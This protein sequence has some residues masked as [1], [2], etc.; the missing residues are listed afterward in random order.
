MR[1]PSHAGESLLT[2]RAAKGSF[3]RITFSPDNR[4]IAYGI[5]PIVTMRNSKEEGGEAYVR[6][7]NMPDLGE[8][9]PHRLDDKG[10]SA[11]ALSPNGQIAVSGKMSA[12]SGESS[13]HGAQIH[14]VARQPVCSMS[15]LSFKR[16]DGG[17]V[18]NPVPKNDSVCAVAFDP[19]RGEPVVAT[20]QESTSKAQIDAK[21]YRIIGW[22][23]DKEGKGIPTE[24]PITALA[25]SPDGK[26]LAAAAVVGSPE[27][28]IWNLESRDPS[29][30]ELRGSTIANLA[31]S[32]DSKNVV[33]AG[34][35]GTLDIWRVG[36]R[37]HLAHFSNGSPVN[38]LAF[39]PDGQILASGRHDGRITLWDTQGWQEIG[40][41]PSSVAWN[42]VSVAFSPKDRVL[43]AAA[44]GS[45][46]TLWRIDS[47]TLK[48]KACHIARRNL[49]FAEWQHYGKGPYQKTCPDLSLSPSVLEYAHELARRG[50]GAEAIALFQRAMDLDPHI[51]LNPKQEVAN[52]FSNARAQDAVSSARQFYRDRPLEAFK[53]YQEADRIDSTLVSA[54]DWNNVCWEGSTRG[55][56]KEVIVACEK[57]VKMDPNDPGYHDS[58]GLARALTGDIPGAITDFQAYLDSTRPETLKQQRRDWIKALQA[59]QTPFTRDLL[60]ALQSH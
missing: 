37:Q 42:S 16:I 46:V 20:C 56:V 9:A 40:T 19:R 7:W 47:A 24:G 39:T 13:D 26:V 28:L 38:D 50:D 3:S 6:T 41:L 21:S 5:N 51:H 48:S 14:E 10:R 18:H 25:V 43:L 11:L 4:L 15:D 52:D 34:E 59:D 30:L 49:T 2:P 36:D 54:L 45:E 57:A 55:F 58:R 23:A 27:I 12:T 22:R 1:D 17:D 33:S 60:K 29:R 32:P 44:A 8:L 53:A 31:F 35:D